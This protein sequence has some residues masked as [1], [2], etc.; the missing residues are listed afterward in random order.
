MLFVAIVLLEDLHGLVSGAGLL[1]KKGFKGSLGEAG[2]HAK[3][4]EFLGFYL[5]K[6]EVDWVDFIVLL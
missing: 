5:S 6:Q 4:C 3:V 1:K 2:A